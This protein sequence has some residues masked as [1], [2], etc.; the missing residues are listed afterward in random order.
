MRQS[1]RSM[2]R[3]AKILILGLLAGTLII[4]SNSSTLLA[5]LDTTGKNGRA[6]PAA[7]AK[8][9]AAYGNLP[10]SFIQNK[11]QVDQRVLFYEQGSGHATALMRDGISLS[12][13]NRQG[14]DTIKLVPFGGNKKPA[15]VGEGLQEGTVNYFVG[16]DH[17]KWRSGI[18]TY[19]AVVYQE[20]YPGIDLKFYGNQRQL[21]YDVIV[22]PGADLSK[23]RFAYEGIK[24]LRVTEEGDLEI[25]LKGSTVLQKK[26]VVYQD[27]AGKRVAVDAG[28]KLLDAVSASAA[29]TPSQDEIASPSARH[30]A[31]PTVAYTFEVASYDKTHTLVI[32]PVLV[33]S[34]YLGGSGNEG[35]DAFGPEFPA[36]L[37]AAIEADA[38]GYAYVTGATTSVDIGLTSG[39]FGSRGGHDA[40]VAKLNRTG[41]GLVFAT[42]LGGSGYD[43]GHA[44][45]I[46]PSGNVYLTGETTSP[47]FP[48]TPGA[49]DPQCGTDGSCNGGRYD[50]FVVKLSPDGVG[51]VYSTYLGGSGYD[52]GHDIA[53][54]L[55]GNAYVTGTT[56]PEPPSQPDFP[57]T[58]GT[59]ADTYQGGWSDAFVTKLT[60]DGTGLAYSTYLGGSG[61]DLG[62]GIALDVGGNVYVTGSTTSDNVAMFSFYDNTCG[63]VAAPCSNTGLFDG[64]V[65][66]LN[67]EGNALLYWTYLGGSDVDHSLGIDL[68]GG[69]K[70]YVTGRTSSSD[71]PT[72]NGAFDT[73]YND[74]VDQFVAVLNMNDLGWPDYIPLVYSTFLGG[75]GAE[76]GHNL[77]LDPASDSVY[78]NGGTTSDDFPTTGDAVDSTCGTDG[79]CN[80]KDGYLVKLQPDNTNENT[81]CAIAGFND[82]ADLLYSTYLGGSGEDIG[83]GLAVDGWGNVYATGRTSS[84]D[85]PT[86]PT[87]DPRAFDTSCG[88]DGTCNGGGSDT[89]V[90]KVGR[91]PEQA[92]AKAAALP[93]VDLH[94]HP[95]PNWD[96]RALVDVLN[97][98]SVV[99]ACNGGG[100]TFDMDDSGVLNFAN[101]PILSRRYL[102]YA[103]MDILR[104]ATFDDQL[105]L[106]DGN[107]GHLS[108]NILEYLSRLES[109]LRQ[110]QFSGIGELFPYN[111]NSHTD[112]PQEGVFSEPSVY[113]ADSPLMQRL[114]ALSAVF[115]VPLSVHMEATRESL[116]QMER[117]L[118]MT[119]DGR[120]GIWVWAHA[121]L[122]DQP[123]GFRELGLPFFPSDPPYDQPPS[124]D[125]PPPPDLPVWFSRLL[126]THENL[127]VELS[128]RDFRQYWRFGIIDFNTG[129]LK[130]EWKDLFEKHSDRF[131]IG[132]DAGTHDPKRYAL[133]VTFW[134]GVLGQLTQNTAENIAF[135]NA[136]GL[137]IP[138]KPEPALLC[139]PREPSTAPVTRVA[140]ASIIVPGDTSVATS[141]T[142]PALPAGF[143]LGNPP[144]YYDV[145]T[146]VTYTGSATVCLNYDPAQY[147]DPTALRLLHYEA[148]AWTDVTTSNDTTTNMICGRV[149]SLSPFAVAEPVAD[150][151]PPVLTVPATITTN[152]T[153]PAGVVVSYS[154]SATDNLD[155]TPVVTCTP[156]SGSTFPI[157][158]TTV[159]CTATDAAGNLATAQF[160][161]IVQ[162]AA[163]QIA[164]LVALVQS[165]NLKQGIENSLDAKLQNAQDAL[166]AAQGGDLPSACNLLNAF[167]NEAQAQSGKAISPDQASQLNA[168]ANQITAVLGCL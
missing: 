75:D 67:A 130:Q 165:F 81:A 74:G 140:F 163:E 126:D 34:T 10:L 84:S 61:R 142:G 159:T 125:Q 131:V 63:T 71:F 66:R 51:L 119:F 164:D 60:P 112:D 106:G 149:S 44:I 155:S 14:S 7:N 17:T 78:V 5:Q 77:V 64:Y 118:D 141:S 2:E 91:T 166:T 57:T 129:K 96:R 79:T 111:R 137:T 58:A 120:K 1:G 134:R 82:C 114:W 24:A 122:F 42:Y 161:V 21:E 76:D 117:L 143:Q 73:S 123:S 15:I 33:Y 30:H 102:P 86:F 151:T 89:F 121:G 72:T 145:T 18:P 47:D 13:V 113:P 95:H 28:F 41:T 62:D 55:A 4:P 83:H 124:Y 110:G 26:P 104:K 87:T 50:A 45:A 19:Q 168:A 11:G 94:F 148:D 38:F 116:A 160:Q 23:V 92:A 105:D 49:F 135:R 37:D 138:E 128:V 133:L 146:T 31:A 80:V 162:G 98:V 69:W 90:A 101:D 6:A 156:P 167:S 157:G 43:G 115:Q 147:S 52:N 100:F 153:S 139:A 144:T 39:Q 154:A 40:F 35:G 93:I 99:T 65:A 109:Q 22:K 88:T 29:T 8:L 158:T 32:D 59:L 70:V 107:A 12:L 97:E 85:F 68:V 108:P 27:I 16:R 25:G 20:I 103:G 48:T 46:D 36:A 127:Y 136:Q 9:Q 53:V 150:T 152:A 56:T 3:G 54:N 132:T